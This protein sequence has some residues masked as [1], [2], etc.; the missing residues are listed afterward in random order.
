[1]PKRPNL[2]I[3]PGDFRWPAEAM[4]DAKL[5]HG[6]PVRIEGAYTDGPEGVFKARAADGKLYR[7]RSKDVGNLANPAAIRRWHRYRIARAVERSNLAIQA[8]LAE[9]GDSAFS[10]LEFRKL[11][12]VSGRAL[13]ERA[14]DMAFAHDITGAERDLSITASHFLPGATVHL[15][16]RRGQG[17]TTVRVMLGERE[18][19]RSTLTQGF[20]PDDDDYRTHLEEEVVDLINEDKGAE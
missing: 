4:K 2:I 3:Q 5:Y 6:H 11:A 17:G 20:S 8:L 18:V 10:W 15:E 13:M 14:A 9:G 19:G 7:L 1:M 16:A 12:K